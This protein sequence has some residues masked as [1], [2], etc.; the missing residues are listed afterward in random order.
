MR[1]ET[2]TLFHV[3]VKLGDYYN[4]EFKDRRDSYYSLRISDVDESIVSISVFLPKDSPIAQQV[5]ETI[6]D[7]KNHPATLEIAFVNGGYD[8]SNCVLITMCSA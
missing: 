6:K 5:F 4:Y 8:Q 2:P 3:Q 7:G 1:T